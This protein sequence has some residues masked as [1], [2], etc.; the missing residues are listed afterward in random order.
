MTRGVKFRRGSTADHS[1]YTGLEGEITVNTDKDCLVVH[2]GATLGG[3]EQVSVASTQTLTNKT[4]ASPSITSP[5]ISGTASASTLGVTGLSTTRNL[6]V[7]GVTTSAFTQSTNLNVTGVTTTTTL[8]VTGFSTARNLTVVGVAT[9]TTFSGNVSSTNIQTTNL[10]VTGVTTAATLRVTGLSTV[11]NS[12]VV[13]VTTSASFRPTAGTT[14]VAPILLT[15]GTNLSAQTSG[16]IEYDGNLIYATPESNRGVILSPQYYFLNADRTGPT[17]ATTPLDIFPVTSTLKA[18]TRYLIEIYMTITKSSATSCILQL[19]TTSASGTIDRSIYRSVGS[20]ANNTNRALLSTAQ[21]SSFEYAGHITATSV[22][23]G[24][25][26][27]N[28]WQ[29]LQ[30]RI[31]V[32]VNSGG[33]VT[34]Y[35]PQIQFSAVPTTSTIVSGANMS[36]YPMGPVGSNTSIGSWT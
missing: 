36:I 2:D 25:A 27:A 23:N 15:A 26:T 13:G 4:L 24:G 33:D 35:S 12:Y 7:I 31:W 29:D 22:V 8:G 16:A 34:G 5:T 17:A 19:L 14:S 3:F 1:N 6:N 30:V 21:V 18:G 11:T 32:D 10:N 9:A 28:S 20:V